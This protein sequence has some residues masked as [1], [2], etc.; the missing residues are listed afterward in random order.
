MVPILRAVDL[1]VLEEVFVVGQEITGGQQH[2]ENL[3][4]VRVQVQL[5]PMVWVAAVDK[6]LVVTEMV[7]EVEDM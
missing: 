1:G 6:H 4:L 2:K 3:L 7:E 5:V